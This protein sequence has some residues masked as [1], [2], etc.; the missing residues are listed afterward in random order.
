MKP[1]DLIELIALAALWGG[2]FLFMRIAAP[3]F[4]PIPLIEVRVAIAAVVLIAVQMVVGRP[5]ISAADVGPLVVLG[6]T[7]S[8]LPFCLLAWATLSVTAGFAAVLNATAP[9]WAAIVAYA[10]L[11]TRLSGWRAAGLVVGFLGV[12]VLTWG[13]A[14]FK[15]GG[16]G[17]AIAAALFATLSYGFAA[18]Y[19][20]R[21]LPS[22]APLAI[23]TGSQIAAAV[24]LLPLGIWLWPAGTISARAWW[25][26]GALGVACTA[27]A[28]LMFYRL[29]A[30]LGPSKAITVTFL[31][32]IFAVAWGH[33][34]LDE[35]LT[36]QL[37]LGCAVVLF[38]TALSTGVWTPRRADRAGAAGPA[39]SSVAGPERR[40]VKP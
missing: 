3:E 17:V 23:A 19:A 24:A 30:R 37:G 2:S 11:G 12:V 35:P 29:I 14:S 36:L 26:V 5:A 15:T 40:T 22:A 10:W 6:I 7:N 31:V 33:A 21:R 39:A 16:S 28:Y 25:S 8:A 4:G 38:G 34:L 18:N 32:P 27:L 13:K 9:L 20:K 1:K